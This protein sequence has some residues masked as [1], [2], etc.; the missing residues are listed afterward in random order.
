LARIATVNFP[1]L[2]AVRPILK[3]AFRVLSIL[4][5]QG[6]EEIDELVGL[7]LRHGHYAHQL[8]ELRLMDA[9]ALVE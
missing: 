1:A 4:A 8:G 5:L 2:A 3:A 9:S 7:G 6:S